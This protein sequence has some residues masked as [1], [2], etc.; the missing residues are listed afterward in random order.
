M[1]RK[2]YLPPARYALVFGDGAVSVEIDVYDRADAFAR[3]QKLVKEDRPATLYEDGVPLAQ[4][5][6]SPSGFWTV[7][8]CGSRAA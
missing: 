1:R 7:S 2:N 4:I 3:A 6:Y 5:G 8:A